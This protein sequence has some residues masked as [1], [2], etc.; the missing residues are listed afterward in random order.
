M[1]VCIT[2]SVECGTRPG[3]TRIVGGVAAKPG[4][5]PWQISMDYK[6]VSGNH[7]CGGSIVAP[8][9]IVTAS[10]CFAYSTDSK[11]YTIV[12]GKQDVF[13]TLT[14]LMSLFNF[15]LHLFSFRIGVN[16][17]CRNATL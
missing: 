10:H 14:K 3:H 2:G 15:I 6:G 13:V 4:A 17:H 12:A 1:P 9:W 5:W 16:V 7:W 11:D 8:N